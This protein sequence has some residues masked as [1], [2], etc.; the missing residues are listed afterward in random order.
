M[1]RFLVANPAF[2]VRKSWW[3]SF[4]CLEEGTEGWSPEVTGV[5]NQLH[6]SPDSAVH[7]FSKLMRGKGW[8]GQTDSGSAP[9]CTLSCSG[10]RGQ[11]QGGQS[12]CWPCLC[13]WGQLS[14]W[15]HQSWGQSPVTPPRAA[16][17]TRILG[18]N[19][20]VLLECG[21]VQLWLCWI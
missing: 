4:S 21:N 2:S 1:C 8:E 13:V 12:C 17:W 16:V 3:S 7:T 6:P 20:D 15:R 14:T 10:H 11:F 5:S 18:Q 19:V 9:R